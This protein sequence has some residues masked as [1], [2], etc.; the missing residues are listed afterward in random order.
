M[1]E[2]SRRATLIDVAVCLISA[3]IV[4]SLLQLF[5]GTPIEP[6]RRAQC[7]VNVRSFAQASIN[8]ETTHGQFPGYCMDFG[9]FAGGS[10]PS[11]PGSHDVPSHR[12]IGTWAVALLPYIDQQAVYDIWSEDRFPI[13]VGPDNKDGSTGISGVGFTEFA[14]ANIPT[15]QC[16][17]A[18]S[19]AKHGVNSYVCNAGMHPIG[20]TS[21]AQSMSA[22][23]GV[24]NNKYSGLSADGVSVPVG[25]SVSFSDI[26]DGLSQTLLFSENVN[27]LPWHRA[28][29]IDAKD[30]ELPNGQSEVREVRYPNTSRYGQGLVWH[31][32]S[33]P[34][35]KV[36]GSGAMQLEEL[37]MTRWN[38]S[39]LARPS[40]YHDEGVNASFADGSIKLIVDTIDYKVYQ[41]MLTPHGRA[42]DVPDPSFVLTDE[43]D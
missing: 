14:A 19:D 12:K 18:T 37:Q 23:N 27:A 7:A 15:F 13:I 39:D 40:S 21:F 38:C 34:L 33:T 17:S 5:L 6:G 4:V 31:T 16:P 24:F 20:N 29:F 35:R 9:T 42:S 30:L 41:A 25:P 1:S 2:N 36:D 22:A 3:V 26:K 11:I 10:D 32:K 43:L 28:G 8:Y